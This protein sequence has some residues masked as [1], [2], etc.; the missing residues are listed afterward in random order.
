MSESAT[1]ELE[2]VESVKLHK[3]GRTDAHSDHASRP[4][5]GKFTQH[6]TKRS[7]A[8]S[9]RIVICKVSLPAEFYEM[10]KPCMYCCGT[11]TAC[12]NATSFYRTSKLEQA[13]R[14]FLFFNE[15]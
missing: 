6:I 10:H 4:Q 3:N 15:E 9:K 12:K 13:R 14:M 5:N 7:I 1:L 8:S 2:M 11:E